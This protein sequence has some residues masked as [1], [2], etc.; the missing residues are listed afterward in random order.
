MNIDFS[1]TLSQAD[2]IKAY[3]EL[4]RPTFIRL[5]PFLLLFVL[6]PII[7]AL[8]TSNALSFNSLSIPLVAAL[9]MTLV[10]GYFYLYGGRQ[11]WHNLP[12][13]VRLPVQGEISETGMIWNTEV[14]ETNFKWAAFTHYVKTTELL[15]LYQGAAATLLPRTFFAD[16]AAW[17]AAVALI[18]SHVSA[19]PRKNTS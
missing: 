7:S 6:I 10:L 13:S 17:N 9:V 19:T 16:D 12:L 3:R 14:G 18:Q 2:Y 1:G 5:V 8:I 4:V 11:A 15:L